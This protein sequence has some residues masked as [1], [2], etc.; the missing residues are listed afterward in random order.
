M[1]WIEG[2]AALSWRFGRCHSALFS[3]Q[4]RWLEDDPGWAHCRTT[5]VPPG[6]W[7]ELGALAAV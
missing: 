6:V 2:P 7:A 1:S 5:R 3:G 4:G